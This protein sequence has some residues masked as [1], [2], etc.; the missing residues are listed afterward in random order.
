MSTR[1]LFIISLILFLALQMVSCAPQ[2]ADE[3]V[4]QTAIAEKE[5]AQTVLATPTSEPTAVPTKAPTKK[6]TKK[7]TATERTKPT[8]TPEEEVVEESQ[9]FINERFVLPHPDNTGY[10]DSDLA[11]ESWTETMDSLARNQAIPKPF[12]WQLAEMPESTRWA[13]VY[14]YYKKVLLAENWS[15]TSDGGSWVTLAHGN[16]MYIGGFIKDYEDKK[17]KIA[18]LFYPVSKSYKSHYFVLYSLRK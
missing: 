14:D 18:I 6:P 9:E 3:S 13:D 1:N 10:I 16:S 5:D 17:E 11:D 15:I 8:A 12:E 2:K 4:V 7:P